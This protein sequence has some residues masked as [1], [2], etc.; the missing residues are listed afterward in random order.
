MGEMSDFGHLQT[1]ADMNSD[2]YTDM[3]TV[4]GGNQVFIHAYDRQ[5]KMFKPWKDFVVDTCQEIRSITVG[6]SSQLM[7]IFVTCS[8][9][10]GTIVKLVDRIPSETKTKAGET[11]YTFQTLQWSL[12][13]ENDS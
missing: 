4:N 1:F 6:R 5:V 8:S 11:E 9:S 2:K 10:S 13:I 12:K 7:R 3:V